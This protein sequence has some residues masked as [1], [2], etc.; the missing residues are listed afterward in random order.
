MSLLTLDGSHGEGGGQILRTA[1]TLS[2]VTGQPVQLTRIRANRSKPG[3]RPQ[4]LTAVR[5]AAAICAAKLTGDAL[6]SQEITFA[7]QAPPQA[8]TY[9][10]D[11]ADAAQG[12]S[13]GSVTLVLQTIL[14]PLAL[15]SGNSRVTLRGGT[16]VPMSPPALYIEK[17]YLPTLF[18]MGVRARMTHR[19]WGF[20]PQGGGELTV[21]ISGGATLRPIALT[22]R[23]D[24]ER[25][26]GVAFVSNLPSHIPQRM[27][28]RA[29]A[30]LRDGNFSVHIE[31]RHVTAPGIGAGIVLFARYTG[32]VAGFEALGRKR[33]PSE[34]VAEMAVDRLLEHHRTLAAVDSHLADQLVLPFVLANGVSEATLS[35]VTPHLLTNVWV[36]QHFDVPTLTVEG[37]VGQ[38]GYLAVAM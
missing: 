24:L 21:E 13:A 16:T 28:G 20:Y 10:F 9:H 23:G 6:G 8:G 36:A 27:S 35:A 32:A 37:E 2:A 29:V 3:L 4:H 14:L 25:V 34:T 33:L 22:E 19:F 26:D 18:D 7:P 5:A 12:G 11:V 31:P 17:V 1:L 38:P 30:L 15:A